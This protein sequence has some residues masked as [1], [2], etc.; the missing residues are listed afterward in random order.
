MQLDGGAAPRF[1]VLL[2]RR[3]RAVRLLARDRRRRDLPRELVAGLLR[4]PVEEPHRHAIDALLAGAHVPPARRERAAALLVSRRVADAVACRMWDLRLP[5]GSG[6]LRTLRDGGVAGH[7]AG[8]LAAHL[9]G[10]LLFLVSWALIGD[11]ALGGRLDGGLI[12]AWA[13]C[14][15]SLVPFRMLALWHQGQIT[16][17]T[18]ALL[19]RRFLAGAL[20]LDPEEVRHQGIGQT[21][22]K[23]LESDAA[24]ALAIEGGLL[25]IA[26][27]VDLLIA[28]PILAAG[29]GGAWQTLLLLGWLGLAGAAG[30]RFFRA[31]RAWTEARVHLTH[32]MVERMVGHETRLVQEP[33]ARWHADEDAALDQ[34][35]Q[36]SREMDAIDARMRTLLPRLWLVAGLAGL[37]PA[38]A[39]S[40]ATPVALAVAIGGVL[41]ARRA[42]DTLCQ[43]L[44]SLALAAIAWRQVAD[45]LAAA[46]RGEARGVPLL[47]VSDPVDD[48]L[49]APLLE[50]H[51]LSYCYPGRGQPV[52]RGVDLRIEHGERI[53]LE[54]DS[55]GG[56]S[57]LGSLLS[58]LRRASSGVLL[59]RGLDG[60]TLGDAGWRRQVATVPQ[61]HDN[62]V[63]TGSMAFNLLIGRRWPPE[64]ADFLEAEQV[65]QELGLGPLLR[66]MPA[67][68]MQVLGATGWQLS[69][70]ERSRLFMA[71]AILRRPSLFVLDESF[72]ALDPLTL[73]QCMDCVLAEGAAVLVIAHP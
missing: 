73:K 39:V 70:G 54:G 52:L 48:D 69:H 9:V 13:M 66:R 46:R 49:E 62:H 32:D 59:L 50:A 53:L 38:V 15:V 63:F 19:K 28:A 26:A 51:G 2:G 10:Y 55:G 27:A 42:L 72:A 29:A 11:G 31:C 43:S 1:L 37:I 25:A 21:L 60:H 5:A 68:L 56:K 57:T 12:G 23:V 36:A 4:A 45:V 40:G 65:C 7:L 34:Y 16:T 20:R 24:G 3:R 41:L 44:S 35:L 67:G 18:G 64:G 58:G 47:A 22:G 30:L 71:R 17:R 14:L 8:F 61:F 6:L 33:R